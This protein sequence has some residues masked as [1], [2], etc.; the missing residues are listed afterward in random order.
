MTIGQ[1]LIYRIIPSGTQEETESSESDASQTPDPGGRD[2]EI[3]PDEVDRVPP[4]SKH[5]DQYRVRE[6]QVPDSA[7]VEG[8]DQSDN[9]A[10]AQRPA[11]GVL[12]VS[13]LTLLWR[14]LS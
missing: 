5:D 12:A 11:R 8:L 14:L 2:K 3:A 4:D 1:V 9:G 6:N 7:F 13:L 10:A